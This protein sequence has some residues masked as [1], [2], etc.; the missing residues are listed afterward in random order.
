MQDTEKDFPR[1]LASS[2]AS[3]TAQL[4]NSSGCEVVADV[5]KEGL[6]RPGHQEQWVLA[7]YNL[8]ANNLCWVREVFLQTAGQVKALARIVVPE[9][10][11][12]LIPWLKEL[13]DQP[14]G[15]ILYKA[16]SPER[17]LMSREQL[18]FS[19]IQTQFSLRSRYCAL[20]A[21]FRLRKGYWFRRSVL[22]LPGA[23]PVHCVVTECFF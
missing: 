16:Y 18:P 1:R 10:E 9:S 21:G 6:R 5:I 17:Q 3:I 12:E 19:Q 22:L 13:G 7:H 20:E 4:R 15:D 2:V 8:S 11:L 23:R 14:L